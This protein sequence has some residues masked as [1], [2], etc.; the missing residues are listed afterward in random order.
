MLHASRRKPNERS[1]PFCCRSRPAQLP[2]SRV[3]CEQHGPSVGDSEPSAFSTVF[4]TVVEN[5]GGRP[6]GSRKGGDCNTRVQGATRTPP[7]VEDIRLRRI[8]TDAG[9]WLLSKVSS[10]NHPFAAGGPQIMKRNVPTESPP[11]AQ[12]PWLP[13]P[14]GHQERPPGAEAPPRQGAQALTVR[15][16]SRRQR[17]HPALSA[18][19]AL[20]RASERESR[21][22]FPALHEGQRVRRRAEFTRV[23]DLALRV[24]GT[25]PDGVRSRPTPPD[26][27][28]RHR[29]HPETRRRGSRKPGQTTDS[30]GFPANHSCRPGPASTSW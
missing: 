10:A 13:G 16:N 26:R 20:S 12:D 9:A 4:S 28:A 15:R 8:D 19:A 27:P 24:A 11:P 23:Y 17:R 3:A 2:P 25:L 22:A 7:G 5:F 6:Y 29:G 14:H 21:D 30:R 18:R 1:R